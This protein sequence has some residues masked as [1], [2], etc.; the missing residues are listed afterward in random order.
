MKVEACFLETKCDLHCGSRASPQVLFSYDSKR[1]KVFA[2][3]TAQA[4]SWRME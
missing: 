3:V 4:R 2:T 1:G